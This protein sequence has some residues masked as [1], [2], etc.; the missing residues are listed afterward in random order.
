MKEREE[1][2]REN[3]TFYRV[4]WDLGQFYAQIC[5]LQVLRHGANT[6]RHTFALC[7]FNDSTPILLFSPCVQLVFVTLPH[8]HSP[9]LCPPYFYHL[10]N[11]EALLAPTHAIT[12]APQEATG[13]HFPQGSMLSPLPPRLYRVLEFATVLYANIPSEMHFICWLK[14]ARILFQAVRRLYPC[15]TL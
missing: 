14:L 4:E 13:S 11:E 15:P 2:E 5:E 8:C 1:R 7:N 6:Q 3:T 10:R 12:N 9:A